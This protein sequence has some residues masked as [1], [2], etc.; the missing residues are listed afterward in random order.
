MQFG[1]HFAF[2]FPGQVSQQAQ[3][4]PHEQPALPG[5][6][7]Q[8]LQ[9]APQVH[10]D[11]HAE[12]HLQSAPHLQPAPEPHPDDFSAAPAPP[13][14]HGDDMVADVKISFETIPVDFAADRRNSSVVS[15][16]FRLM[17]K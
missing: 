16:S 5:H 4:A 11:L 6:E 9:S 15:S 12:Q 13:L 8:H 17:K 7:E 14:Q 2:A 10:P 3:L 1:P